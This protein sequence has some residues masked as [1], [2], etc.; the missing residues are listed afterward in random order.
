MTNSAYYGN[1][2][3]TGAT[4]V[5][6]T[7]APILADQLFKTREEAQAA[8]DGQIVNIYVERLAAKVQFV[9][10]EQ[11]IKDFKFSDENPYA[12]TFVPEIWTINADEPRE[13]SIKRFDNTD[14]NTDVIPTFAE[15]N[16]MLG[17][18]TTWNDPALHR[19]YWG[20]SPSYYSTDF[21][22]VSDDIIDQVEGNTLIGGVV[23][24][25]HGAGV[26]VGDFALR[27]YSY[28]QI[29]DPNAPDYMRGV[30]DYKAN[31]MGVLPCK[32]VMEN[33]MGLSSFNSINPYACSP[34]V[35]VIGHY[36]LKYNG[37]TVTAPAG[38]CIYNNIVYYKDLTSEGNAGMPEDAMSIVDAMLNQNQVLVNAAGEAFN[39]KNIP[40]ELKALFEVVHP[41]KEIRG[42][43]AVPHRYVTLQIKHAVEGDEESEAAWRTL[44]SN[45]YFAEAG[46][47]QPVQA[48]ANT[49][50]GVHEIVNNLNKLLW[51][52]LGIAQA[53]T[54]NKCYYSIPIQHLGITENNVATSPI[55]ADGTIDWKKARRGDFGLVRNHVYTIKVE[56]IEGL[57][58]G[59]QDPDNP[60]VPSTPQ[61][62][63]FVKYRINILNWR[64]VPVQG[65]IVLK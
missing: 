61:D 42:T 29:T 32:Y 58:H 2:P 51:Q 44:L 4:N 8:K 33:T 54:N 60:L 49:N 31:D 55:N 1:N 6:M 64:I 13:Y 63:Y 57:A 38:F 41:S 25:Q 16:D 10:N 52:Q 19:S 24:S 18:W 7:G 40:E 28:N 47:Q 30:R 62:S 22:Q 26:P 37:A 20:C 59:I 23:G 11:G 27:Y 14:A 50:L 39:S 35:L 12:L 21:P 5:K 34:S 46:S 65:D 56:S 3:I 45:F 15:V 36:D 48:T 53:Y 17:G 43:Q 9:L